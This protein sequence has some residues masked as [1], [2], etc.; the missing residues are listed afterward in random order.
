MSELCSG[1][2]LYGDINVRFRIKS[3]PLLQIDWD[4]LS[5]DEAMAALGAVLACEL[6]LHSGVIELFTFLVE[7]E[8]VLDDV[9]ED[10]FDDA[11]SKSDGW[12]TYVIDPDD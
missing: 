1:D 6:E 12:F 7:E 11:D 5:S 10:D 3:H 8:G 9:D 2:K 4:E